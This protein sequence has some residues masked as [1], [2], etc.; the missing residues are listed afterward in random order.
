MRRAPALLPSAAMAPPD[1]PHGVTTANAGTSATSWDT[2][3]MLSSGRTGA[4]HSAQSRLYSPSGTFPTVIPV[5]FGWVLTRVSRSRV[6]V[7]P[8][9]TNS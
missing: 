2:G 9:R 8:L 7:P 5:C 3:P 6:S 1:R 4:A